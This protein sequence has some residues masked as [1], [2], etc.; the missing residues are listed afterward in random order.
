MHNC[1]CYIDD[2]KYLDIY[3]NN[4]NILPDYE[5]VL[6]YQFCAVMS[7][8]FY[9]SVQNAQRL[10]GENDMKKILRSDTPSPLLSPLTSLSST[11]NVCGVER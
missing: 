8:I 4:Y 7:W 11:L 10:S 2:M 6:F 3:S 1:I 9:S 5:M